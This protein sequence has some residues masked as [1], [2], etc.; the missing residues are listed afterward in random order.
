VVGSGKSAIDQEVM[1]KE[2]LRQLVKD[3]SDKFDKSMGSTS[4]IENYT[5]MPEPDKLLIEA[6]DPSATESVTRLGQYP[7]QDDLA[8]KTADE[9]MASEAKDFDLYRRYWESAWS[10]T[11]GSFEHMSKY[12]LPPIGN[13]CRRL[14]TTVI[15]DRREYFLSYKSIRKLEIYFSS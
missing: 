1:D 13:N 2:T 11:C 9:E 5:P 8:K 7:V 4:A 3:L 12:I 15:S 14:S 6:E 10:K